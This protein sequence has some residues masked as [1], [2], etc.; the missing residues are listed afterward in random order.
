MER[1]V[2]NFILGLWFGD[3][4]R[5]VSALS[6]RLNHGWNIRRFTALAKYSLG[7]GHHIQLHRL[8]TAQLE[9]T[10]FIWTVIRFKLTRLYQGSE[11]S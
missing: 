5:S 11:C 8:F 9:V 2:T 4:L 7:R 6:I 3:I 1:V 10:S